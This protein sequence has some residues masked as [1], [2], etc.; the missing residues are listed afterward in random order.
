MSAPDAVV[1]QQFGYSVSISADNVVIGA[2]GDQEL[3]GA[4]YAFKTNVTSYGQYDYVSKIVP[5][6]VVSGHQFG[7]SVGLYEG[8]DYANNG[9]TIP[10]TLV[11]GAPGNETTA[12]A[13]AAFIYHTDDSLFPDWKLFTVLGPAA[14]DANFGKSVAIYASIIVSFFICVFFLLVLKN[15]I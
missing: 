6:T 8:S 7:F 4:V 5:N 2:P 12:L 13:G 10:A 15:N 9:D 3:T 1:D 14:G 11:V